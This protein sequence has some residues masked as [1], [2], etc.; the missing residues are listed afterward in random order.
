MGDLLRLRNAEGV[1]ALAASRL[2]EERSLELKALTA[3]G[4]VLTEVGE[5]GGSTI[6]R[7]RNQT[8]VSRDQRRDWQ[9]LAASVPR[10]A[11]RPPVNVLAY[12]HLGVG[13][14]PYAGEATL[15][16]VASPLALT[17]ERCC[18]K[19]AGRIQ[20]LL[21][22]D[23]VPAGP[24]EESVPY[25][26][27]VGLDMRRVSLP[28]RL[29]PHR[30][31]A[32]MLTG[33]DLRQTRLRGAVLVRAD[34][35]GTALPRDLRAMTLS[36]CD[37]RGACIDARP[38]P[39]TADARWPDLGN[40]V[41][42][43]A[44]VD[45]ACFAQD[46]AAHGMAALGQLLDMRGAAAHRS[47]L[48]SLDTIS[49]EAVRRDAV[50][51]LVAAVLQCLDMAVPRRSLLDALFGEHGAGQPE[52]RHRYAVAL[53]AMLFDPCYTA[54]PPLPGI[55]AL[56]LQLADE[57]VAQAR[58]YNHAASAGRG[59]GPSTAALARRA[60]AHRDFPAA[61]GIA[62]RRRNPALA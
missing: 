50:E 39:D 42:T 53:A 61:H 12:L 41:L 43:G 54:A 29:G 11:A 22:Q 46:A 34:L 32:L 59:S 25:Q 20:N 26:L 5:L 56:R 10:S 27:P 33:R 49:D 21:C 44:V 24:G 45:M 17:T 7:L 19:I 28:D 18:R 52:A 4:S 30:L 3:L 40:A 48:C 14:V 6:K 57:L 35:R 15:S 9:V 23:A 37:L 55:A 13:R 36:G 47:L 58:A 60:I 8:L 51:R 38:M 2:N 16:C 62:A 31:E 1:R